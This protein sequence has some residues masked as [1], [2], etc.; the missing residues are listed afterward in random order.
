MN[1][2]SLKVKVCGM[3]Y[4]DNL[5]EVDDLGIDY[6]G[7]IF[8]KGSKRYVGDSKFQTTSINAIPV[9]VFVNQSIEEIKTA[10]TTFGIKIAQL[11]GNETPDFC[12]AV[13]D[14]GLQV[15]KVLGV[16]VET[17]FNSIHSYANIV[18]LFLFD[19]KSPLHGGTGIK[20]NWKVLQSVPAGVKFMLSGGI[21]P[22]DSSTINSL[23]LPGL[24]GIDLNSKFEVSPGLKNIELLK[25]FISKEQ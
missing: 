6:Y 5:T 14:I 18:D 7:M 1:S 16:S 15:W 4:S 8:F 9:G 11:H 2:K 21:N 22:D 12:Q 17:D 23:D 25:S 13:K 3:K 10:Q 24:V 20:F 19:T